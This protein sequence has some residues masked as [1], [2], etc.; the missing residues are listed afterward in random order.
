MPIVMIMR[1]EGM[2]AEQYDA[3]R[4]EVNLEADPPSGGK[5]HVAAFDERGLVVVDLWDSPEAFNAFVETRLMPAVGKLGL[6]GRPDVQ[7]AS[8]HTTFT[9]G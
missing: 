6:P 1:W 7:M 9:Q 5:L 8:V 3:M 4:R 2:T